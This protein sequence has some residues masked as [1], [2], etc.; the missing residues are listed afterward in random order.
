MNPA[1]GS[2]F[3]PKFKEHYAK[4][5][6]YALIPVF[7]TPAN[8]SP[9]WDLSIEKKQIQLLRVEDIKENDIERVVLPGPSQPSQGPDPERN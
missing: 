5:G 7:G 8:L 1:P 3:L 2:P 4:H 9:A 6:A